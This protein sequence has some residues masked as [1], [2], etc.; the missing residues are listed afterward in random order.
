MAW[1]KTNVLQCLQCPFFGKCVLD[2]YVQPETRPMALGTYCHKVRADIKSGD[3]DL[4]TWLQE[5]TD[6]EAAAIIDTTFA[7]DPHL[8]EHEG[9][10]LEQYL[11]IDRTG[12]L[13]GFPEDVPD[14]FIAGIL[15]E[16][17]LPLKYGW[18][19]GLLH[20]EDYKT[21]WVESVRRP[22]V[23]F[24]LLLGWAYCKAA[25]IEV[26]RKRFVY[27]YG[28]SGRRVTI[29]YTGS[30]D[31]LR[32]EAKNIIRQVEALLE[33]PIPIPGSHCTTCPIIT[34]ECPLYVSIPIL[35]D[36]SIGHAVDRFLSTGSMTPAEAPIVGFALHAIEAK[37][38]ELKAAIK[39]W[40]I[41]NGDIK[42]GDGAWIV[43]EYPGGRWN[44][45]VALDILLEEGTPEEARRIA[46]GVDKTRI[47]RLKAFPEVRQRLYKYAYIPGEPEKRMRFKKDK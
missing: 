18:R 42:I 29:D 44:Q 25:H 15:D 34:S 22:E 36:K 12:S 19:K 8:G 41:E 4:N 27:F 7:N 46:L 30:F 43:S 16:L 45:E 3:L 38:A 31:E 10:L 14:G 40:I 28:R 1:H 35:A 2:G 20:V 32:I 47:N 23:V 5:E 24:Y 11:Q 39:P 33:N 21:G 17:Y 26:D 13:M 6:D 9:V 37:I